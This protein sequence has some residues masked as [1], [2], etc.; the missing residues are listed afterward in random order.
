MIHIWRCWKYFMIQCTFNTILLFDFIN[1][2]TNV[3]SVFPSW[4]FLS[5]NSV[6][7]PCF[8]LP[9]FI[10]QCNTYW[11]LHR[12]QLMFVFCCAFSFSHCI[13]CHLLIIPLVFSNFSSEGF[14]HYDLSYFYFYFCMYTFTF[15]HCLIKLKNALF[16][17]WCWS[18][19]YQLYFCIFI[20]CIF[21]TYKSHWVKMTKEIEMV[22]N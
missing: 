19:V 20:S 1:L 6:G 3:C 11:V 4:H 21:I 8:N 16:L 5:R 14:C 18:F 9:S 2:K 22:I 10:K 12:K 17:I 13:V 7:A 15:T